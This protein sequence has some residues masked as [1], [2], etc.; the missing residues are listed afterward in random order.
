MRE[1]QV[2]SKLIK[3]ILWGFGGQLVIIVLG[4]IVPRIMITSYG[5]DTNGLLS[6]IGQ[7]FTYMALLEA[8]IGQATKI[9]LYKPISQKD[10]YE[11][12]CVVSIATRYYNKISVLYGIG[13]LLLSAILPLIIKTELTYWTVFFVVLFEGMSGVVTF[14][15]VQTKRTILFADGKGYVNN[16]V[17]VVN[18]TVS[19]I[20][21]IAMATFEV[22]IVLIQFVYF[23]L[24]VITI[25][26]Y[27]VYFKKYY[28]WI[29]YHAGEKNAKLKDR[30][31]FIITEI[32]WTIFSS[33]DMIV[34]SAFLSTKMA[35]VYGVYALVFMNLNTLLSTVYNGVNYVLGQTFF[36]SKEKY[37]EVHDVFNS[38]FFGGMT[39]LM[40]IAYTLIIPFIKLY[41]KGVSDVNYIIDLLPTLFCLVQ[42]LSWSRYVT[43]NLSGIAGYAKPTS[44]ISL[45]EALINVVL[46]VVLVQK[47]GIT[48]V[49]FATV[50]ALPLKV[51]YLTIL[52]D[53]V[54][55]KRSCWI[56]LKIMCLNYAFFLLTVV[57]NQKITLDIQNYGSFFVHGIVVSIVFFL[58]GAV[59][60]YIANPKLMR[61]IRI[62]R[63]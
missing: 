44:K 19:Y 28:P 45:I 10:E 41:T 35:S 14:L 46:S 16:G 30:N 51:V 55:L 62:I 6:T 52:S 39:T 27:T 43:G 40:C 63:K 34:L 17:S 1:N 5:S 37:I 38:I 24:T 20:V 12:S 58:L 22:N 21:K 60:N 23:V 4:I 42:I 49:L 48:G 33:T 54:I 31:S 50:A 26:F 8:G 29:D 32:A 18:K 25:L 9:A 36:E 3:N 53:R 56:T 61:F 13:V 11:F 15:F 59:L 7:I 47:Y 57:V 2:K